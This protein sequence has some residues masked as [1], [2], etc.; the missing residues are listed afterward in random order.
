MTDHNELE[1]TPMPWRDEEKRDPD[2]PENR[3]LNAAEHAA[4]DTHFRDAMMRKADREM[5]LARAGHPARRTMVPYVVL[6]LLGL[7]LGVL[8]MVFVIP[9]WWA[10]DFDHACLAARRMT[11]APWPVGVKVVMTRQATAD[12][13]AYEVHLMCGESAYVGHGGRP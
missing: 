8:L 9:A 7:A 4:R 1:G 11:N 10:M 12:T 3:G 6:V 13:D 5:L 2:R